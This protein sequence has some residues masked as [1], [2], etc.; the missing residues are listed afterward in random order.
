MLSGSKLYQ[1]SVIDCV[2]RGGLQGKI[3]EKA[4]RFRIQVYRTLGL[5]FRGHEPL[6]ERPF[7]LPPILCT[8]PPTSRP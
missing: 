5:E 8:R 1:G 4:G 7:E 2:L 6:D 3:L